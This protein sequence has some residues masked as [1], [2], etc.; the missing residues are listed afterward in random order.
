MEIGD[1]NR[2]SS[3]R[4]A[5]TP[6]SFIMKQLSITHLFIAVC[7]SSEFNFKG[8][9]ILNLPIRGNRYKEIAEMIF[10]SVETLNSHI[11]NIYRKV[12]VHSMAEL[13]ARFG[14]SL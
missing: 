14:N 5:I 9:K 10:I 4:N 7:L 6:A 13:A 8:K 11:K 1:E 2:L 12:N 3:D